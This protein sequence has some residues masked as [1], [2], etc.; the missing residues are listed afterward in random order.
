[1]SRSRAARL[2]LVLM[3]I[4]VCTRALADDPPYRSSVVGTRFDMITEKDPDA[5]L[6]L[7]S[8]GKALEEMPDKSSQAPLRQPAFRFLATFKDGTTVAIHV[9]ADVG[10]AER[11]K[12]EALRYTPRLG[13]LPTSLRRGV[14]RLVVHHGNPDT[15]AFSDAG[16]IV[17]YSANATRRIRTHDLE[18]TIFHES[19]HAAWDAAHARSTAWRAAQAKDG[20][21]ATA[22]GK[23]KPTREDLAESALFAFVLLH[24]PGRIPSADAARIRARIPARIAFVATLLPVGRPLHY[25][26]GGKDDALRKPAQGGDAP[27]R[28]GAPSAG[29]RSTCKVDL[30]SAG[31]LADILS[32]VLLSALKQN[33]GAVR[34]FLDGQR[35]L[36]A[37]VLL[38][39]TAT[40]FGVSLER[41]RA[42]VLK[43]KHVNCTHPPIDPK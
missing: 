16:L 27:Q 11:A 25:R 33:E 9:D 14:Q 17:V 21:F 41:L 35:D 37:D 19:V 15:T 30:S 23:R 40:R 7:E 22:Y 26:L 18:E 6:R 3:S 10:T 8:R 13:R 34:A 1:M 5:F 29:Q 31:T 4:L 36:S 28:E 43:F 2:V 39:R 12:A 32:N 38:Q 20:R 42:L 24:H